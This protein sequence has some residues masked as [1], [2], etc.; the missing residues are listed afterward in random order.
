MR[1]VDRLMVEELQIELLQMVGN[2][3]RALAEQARRQ[4]GGDVRNARVGVLAGRGGDGGGGLTAARR[5]SIWGADVSVILGAPH[6]E[7]H[8]EPLRAP[9]CS[10]AA[11]LTRRHQGWRRLRT[12]RSTN[13]S[14]CAKCC[15]GTFAVTS[16]AIVVAAITLV[17]AIARDRG[18]APAVSSSGS[19]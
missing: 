2:A 18:R 6:S 3:G 13:H 10:A 12:R 17:V 11:Q 16:T 14:P 7:F 8:G 9:P 15:G 1:E 5:L 4:L 19:A